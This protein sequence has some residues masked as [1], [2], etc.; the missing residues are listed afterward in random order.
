M[1]AK[2]ET[3]SGLSGLGDL[4]TTCISQ[5]SRNRFVGEQIGK[6][7]QLKDILSRMDMVAEGVATAQSAY[8]LS[9]RYNVPM[10]I[11][12]QAYAVLYKHKN[13]LK[14]VNDL[15]TREKRNE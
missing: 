2:K 15:M 5:Y 3:F 6:G 13:P 9:K 14:A 8:L 4:V 11:T 12:E 7:R 1:G 10:P